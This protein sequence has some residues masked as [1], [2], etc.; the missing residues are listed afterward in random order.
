M[1]KLA[2]KVTGEV[3]LDNATL[4]LQNETLTLTGFTGSITFKPDA[5]AL[6]GKVE[7]LQS[8]NPLTKVKVE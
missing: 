5:I 2:L 1:S 7:S 6:N 8:S 4:N 3:K